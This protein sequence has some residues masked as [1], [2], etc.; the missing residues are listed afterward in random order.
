[1]YLRTHKIRQEGALL[2]GGAHLQKCSEK[3]GHLSPHTRHGVPSSTSCASKPCR[4]ERAVR[5][6]GMIRRKHAVD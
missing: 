1:M 6:Q 2:G 4:K 5:S 3:P